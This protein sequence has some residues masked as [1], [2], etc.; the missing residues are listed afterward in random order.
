[1]F[2][3]IS[4][5]IYSIINCLIV[6]IVIYVLRLEYMNLRWEKSYCIILPC[7]LYL[8]AP[9]TGQNDTADHTFWM[10]CFKHLCHV[11]PV[12]F[13]TNCSQYLTVYYTSKSNNTYPVIKAG[14]NI[15]KKWIILPWFPLYFQ[16]SEQQA[17]IKMRGWIKALIRLRRCTGWSAPL[18]MACSYVRFSL[19]TANNAN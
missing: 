5:A 15:L 17:L 7:V 8:F 12:F 4:V 13:S 14:K 11:M 16:E 10:V 2:N 6:F 19:D 1:M 3:H 9:C 18:L